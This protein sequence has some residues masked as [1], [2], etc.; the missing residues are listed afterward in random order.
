MTSALA[1]LETRSEARLRHQFSM[2][3]GKLKPPSGHMAFRKPYILS[4]EDELE[5]N[6]AL[7]KQTV[8]P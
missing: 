8:L 1:R 7:T 3:P 4:F 5:Y 2:E 6:Q